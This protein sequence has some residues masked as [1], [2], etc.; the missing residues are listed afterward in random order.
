MDN[1]NNNMTKGNVFKALL[2]FTIPLIISGF[3]Q[4]LYTIADSVIVGNFIS[5]AALAA[6]GVSSPVSNVFIYVITGLVSGYT[7]LIS[8][9]YGAKDY[10]KVLKLTN[11]FFIF[12]TLFSFLLSFIGF[13]LKD[14]ILVLL[15]TPSE[16][17]E[18]S[19]EYLSIVF[20]GVPFLVIYNLYSSLLR[21]IGNSKIPLY[22][23]ILSSAINIILDLIFIN[24]FGLGIK[25]AAIAT[26]IAQIISC[27][28][29][30]LY[31]NKYYSMFKVNFKANSI[32]LELFI[33]SLRLSVPRVI[34]SAIGSLGELLL[35]NIMN[36]FGFNV[37]TAITT[38]YKIDTLTILPII[39]ISIAISIFVGQNVGA[40]NME[41]AKEGLKKGIIIILTL[42]VVVTTVVVLAGFNLM[43]FFGV[44]NEVAQIGQNFFYICG[45]FYPVFG[46][47]NAYSSFLQGN[48]DVNFTS[49][50][51]VMALGVRLFLSYTLAYLIGYRIIA[52]AE[53]CSWVFG[54]VMYYS[55]YK[56]NLWQQYSMFK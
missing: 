13:S 10:D 40:G 25:G 44:S 43:K 38:A 35:Q 29:L 16:I 5:E 56:S 31:V 20:M 45:V 36:S 6:V 33:E 53:M 18:Q 48:K 3:L 30:Y 52:V 46:L 23:I 11:T 7:I 22:S 39:N 47:E 27:I 55:R 14:N 34:Q 4:Q 12:V 42:S 24:T 8:Q 17:L 26:V 32:N 19:I 37:V 9:Y 41:R 49:V 51:S 1:L 28:Y 15:N 50:I 54:A 2:Y 21:G